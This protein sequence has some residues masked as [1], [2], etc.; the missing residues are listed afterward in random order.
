MAKDVDINGFWSIKGNPVTKEGVFPYTGKQIDFNGSLGL[1]PNK[2]Y[3][4]YRPA[5]ELSKEETLESFNGVPLIDDHEMVGEGC[6]PYDDRAAAGVL[7]NPRLS[8]TNAGMIVGD[9]K[10]FS[11]KL[12]NLIQQGKK[13]LSL[14]YRC[15]YDAVKGI[16]QGQ[17]YDFIQRNMFGNHVALVNEGRMGSSVRVYDHKATVF[18]SIEAIE[19]ITEGKNAMTEAE[20]KAKKEAEE[21][22]AAESKA[23]DE[24]AEAEKKAKEEAE[25]KDAEPA[26]EEKQEESE[27]KDC[28]DEDETKEE[29]KE[30]KKAD[31]MDSAAAIKAAVIQLAERDALVKQVQ[32]LVGAF[33][34][35]AMLSADDVA[36]YACSK[37]KLDAGK[38]EAKAMIK[39]FLAGKAGSGMSF[40]QDAAPKSGKDAALEK[41]LKGEK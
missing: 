34:T 33:D 36:V 10:I 12:K 23:A 11:E 21:K 24:A 15:T 41:Y 6:T 7:M 4:V 20:E 38:G 16:W 40:A 28:N 31:S 32:P 5:A 17:T 19:P 27:A 29:A 8:E 37:L 9:F 18:D 30:E 26:E 25:A 14:G 3:N 13:A 22:A 39:G 35:A 2:L 1:E